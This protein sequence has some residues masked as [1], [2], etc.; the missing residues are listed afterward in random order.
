LLKQE[1]PLLPGESNWK[2]DGFWIKGKQIFGQPI[3]DTKSLVSG[4]ERLLPEL[5]RE[6]ASMVCEL[7]RMAGESI[8]RLDRQS[9]EAR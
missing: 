5:A 4:T 7:I 8:T 6:T 2:T 9:A 3:K 1:L